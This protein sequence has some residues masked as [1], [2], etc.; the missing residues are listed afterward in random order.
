MNWCLAKQIVKEPFKLTWLNEEQKILSTF[1]AEQIKRIVNWKAVKGSEPR[2]KA[3][4]LC[5]LHTG[6]RVDELLSLA[7]GDVDF[8]AFKLRVKGQGNKQ[9]FVPMSVE[10]RKF[11]YRHL[12]KNNRSLVFTA[13]DGG[14]LS[15]RN[16]LRDFK[17][18]CASMWIVGTGPRIA[19]E[20]DTG[21]GQE[22]FKSAFDNLAYL[23]LG[24]EVALRRGSA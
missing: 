6:M 3:L 24:S 16:V 4:V 17:L 15:Q 23:V 12:A 22:G 7:P 18:M 8:E 21:V 2:L 13:R 20:R 5:A 11:L 19:G 10:L 1:S 14:K 9:R